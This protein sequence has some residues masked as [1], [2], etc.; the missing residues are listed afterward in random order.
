MLGLGSSRSYKSVVLFTCILQTFPIFRLLSASREEVWFCE[1]LHDL[2][3]EMLL[4]VFA[5]AQPGG[6]WRPSCFV[7][8]HKGGWNLRRW[9]CWILPA[10]NELPVAQL[11]GFRKAVLIFRK[12]CEAAWGYKTTRLSVNT[13]SQILCPFHSPCFLCLEPCSLAGLARQ[14]Q[15]CHYCPGKQISSSALLLYDVFHLLGEVRFQL[16]FR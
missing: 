14:G 4:S 1:I 8:L 2:M 16:C 9:F 7:S 15:A 5:I 6:L 12:G 11:P 3:V 13:P 10:P